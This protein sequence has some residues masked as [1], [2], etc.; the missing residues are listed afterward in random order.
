[1]FTHLNQEMIPHAFPFNA[2]VQLSFPNRTQDAGVPAVSN[3]V[4]F[5]VQWWRPAGVGV[6]NL[7]R[8]L[9]AKAFPEE[10]TEVPY[11]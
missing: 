9:Q 2:L 3:L 10:Y 8:L 4:A 7:V 1:M 6:N 11:F 5:N